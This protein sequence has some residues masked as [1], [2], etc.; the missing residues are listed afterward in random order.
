MGCRLWG[1]TSRTRLL[2]AASCLLHFFPGD[3]LSQDSNKEAK[4]KILQTQIF[5]TSA[6]DDIVHQL[7]CFGLSWYV[8]V[9]Y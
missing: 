5:S 3:L 8:V 9:S 2:V 4:E 6:D 7:R 1:H